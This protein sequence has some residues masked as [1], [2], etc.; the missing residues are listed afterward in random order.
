MLKNLIKKI[1]ITV[2][3]ENTNIFKQLFF[4]FFYKYIIITFDNNYLMFIFKK[5]VKN[6]IGT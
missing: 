5:N 6:K 2:K 1:K 4:K 3:P